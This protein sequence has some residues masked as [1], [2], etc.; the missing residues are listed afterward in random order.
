MKPQN[1]PK[2]IN[3]KLILAHGDWTEH[4]ARPTNCSSKSL[5]IKAVIFSNRNY[6]AARLDIRVFLAK[7]LVY[8]FAAGTILLKSTIPAVRP[9]IALSNAKRLLRTG[10]SSTMTMTAAKNE[11]TG[12]EISATTCKTPT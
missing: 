8:A 3:R 5:R 2:K 1:L 7:L 6:S 11:S 10:K 12:A 9:V 4:Y